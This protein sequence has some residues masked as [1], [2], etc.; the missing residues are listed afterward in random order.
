MI[1]V[2]D[3]AE[4]ESGTGTLCVS[5]ERGGIELIDQW[6]EE[7]RNLCAEAVDDQPF[8]RPEWI[9]AFF[10]NFGREKKVRLISVRSQKHLCLLLPLLEELATFSKVPLRRLR[11][12]V[13]GTCGRF[14]AVRQVGQEGDAAIQATWD[15]LKKLDGWDLLQFSSALDGSTVSQIAEA[16]RQ[17]GF[18]I[19]RETDKPNPVVPVPSDPSALSQMP[20]NSKLRSQLRQSRRR[21]T[22]QGDLKFYRVETADRASLDRFY[23]LEASGWK[24]KIRSCALYDGS[25]P[26]YD[27]VAEQAA[28]FG[29]LS[30]YMLEFNGKLIASH[31]SFNYRNRCYSPKVAYDEDFKLYAPGHLIISE[32]LQ[33][34]ASSGIRDY[35]ITGQ[36]QSWKMKW[37]NK[38]RAVNHYFIFK[39]P[40][41]RLAYTVGSR[42]R[43]T[44]ERWFGRVDAL[45]PMQT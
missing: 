32:I 28:R 12:P 16:A 19:I 35:D 9:K 22:E 42:L 44:V 38:T 41:G 17:D 34:C 13:N 24:G 4:V 45:Q 21:L 18:L 1:A 6:A 11:S 39:G 43:P 5:S 7:W 23:R 25:L 14:D 2:D 27:E 40:V 3:K 15:Y 10:R 30:L 31:F 29:Y 8:Y 36:D 20:P 26:F 37:T 33:D